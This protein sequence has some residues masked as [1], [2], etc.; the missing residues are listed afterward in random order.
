MGATIVPERQFGMVDDTPDAPARDSIAEVAD[1]SD[2]SSAA[3]FIF[4]IWQHNRLHST[5]LPSMI[6]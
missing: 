6:L 1:G 3:A 5:F 4:F 2:S